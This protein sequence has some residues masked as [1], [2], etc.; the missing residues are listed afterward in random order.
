MF[1]FHFLLRSSDQFQ[2]YLKMIAKARD[3]FIQILN[4]VLRKHR[5]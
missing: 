2:I 3:V 4:V 5:I 1:E